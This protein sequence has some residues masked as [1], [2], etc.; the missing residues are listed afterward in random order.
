MEVENERDEKGGS[1]SGLSESPKQSVGSVDGGGADAAAETT[2]YDCEGEEDP[3]QVETESEAEG[4][5][6]KEKE[7]TIYEL[8]ND[9][10]TQMQLLSYLVPVQTHLFTLSLLSALRPML[11]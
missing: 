1:V 9:L 8:V 10:I 4:S 7:E 3:D 2:P 5:P 6:T 11:L